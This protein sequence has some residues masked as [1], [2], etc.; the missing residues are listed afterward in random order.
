[1]SKIAKIKE[2]RAGRKLCGVLTLKLNYFSL[3]CLYFID[4]KRWQD[5]FLSQAVKLTASLFLLPNWDVDFLVHL[6]W[7]TLKHTPNCDKWEYLMAKLK[8]KARGTSMISGHKRTNHVKQCNILQEIKQAHVTTSKPIV[9][10]K[11]MIQHPLVASCG[12]VQKK[13][14]KVLHLGLLGD[15]TCVTYNLTTCALTNS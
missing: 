6:F 12:K 15:L 9:V 13:E 10:W 5:M 7:P 3:E 14:Q 2:N 8:P 11:L 4:H 1:M